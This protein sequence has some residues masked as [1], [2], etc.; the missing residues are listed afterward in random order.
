MNSKQLVDVVDRNQNLVKDIVDQLKILQEKVVLA[1]SCTGGNISSNFV[2]ESG[3]SEYF[4]GSLVTYRPESK[5][6]WLGV[7]PKTIKKSTTESK[8]V[9]DQMA[10]GALCFTP[11]ADW[12]V[13]IVGHLGPNAPKE[14][15]GQIWVSIG[16]RSRTGRVKIKE[17]HEYK[18]Q[19]TDRAE[20]Q[21]TATEIALTF[22]SRRLNRQIN[23]KKKSS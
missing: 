2:K 12:S 18:L 19:S 5:K 6:N 21:R 15:D 20:R 3:V 1:E 17:S 16:R 10:L 8:E 7:K 14:V 22:F 11:E 13:A 23:K 4:C 9:V